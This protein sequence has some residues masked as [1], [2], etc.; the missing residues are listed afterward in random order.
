MDQMI[1]VI[2]FAMNGIGLGHMMRSINIAKELKKIIKCEVLFVTNSPF[3]KFFKENNFRFL[4][5]GADPLDWSN[6]K[7]S[8]DDYLKV[9]QEFL[10][11]AI[12]DFAPDIIVYDFLIMPE[13]IQ[14]AKTKNIFSVYVLREVNSFDYLLPFKPY[15]SFFDL[16]L[17]TGIENKNFKENAVHAGFNKEK[18]F[19]VGNIFRTAEKQRIP[20]MRRKYHKRRG[21][22]LVTITMGG[23]GAGA[24]FLNEIKKFMF[25][26]AAMAKKINCPKKLRWLFI[27]GPLFPDTVHLPAP[28]EVV[29]Y[30]KELPELFHI[31]DLILATG[32]YNTINE[33]IG[34]KRPAL[35]YPLAH[36]EKFLE[37]QTTRVSAYVPK[38]FIKKLDINDHI[39]SLKILKNVLRPSVLKAMKLAYRH[40]RH[41]NGA[42]LAARLI[43]ENF[44]KYPIKRVYVGVLKDRIDTEG[45]HFIFEEIE[46]FRNYHPVYFCHGLIKVRR[47]ID[48]CHCQPYLR[49]PYRNLDLT[50]LSKSGLDRFQDLIRSNHIKILYAEFLTDAVSNLLLIRRSK[51]PTVINF[52][53]FEL[54][55]P[56]VIYFLKQIA[57]AA[58]KIIA[59]SRFQKKELMKRGIKESKIEVIYT[60]I[61]PLT[62]PFKFRK[63]DK[64]KLRLLSAG[65]FVEKKGFDITLRFY[66]KLVQLYPSSKLV[67]VGRGPLKQKIEDDIKHLGLGRHI[68]LK[69][70]MDHDNFIRELYEHD[71]FILP[72]QKTDSADQEGIPNVLK[73]AM[74]S[75]LPVIST[76]HAGIPELITDSKTGFLAPERDPLTLLKKVEF[77]TNN[78]KQTRQICLN[79]RSFVEKNFNVVRTAGQIEDLLRKIS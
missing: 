17:L 58:C 51:L 29:E 53:G 62:I 30:E 43:K 25:T 11:A 47:K 78:K 66:K 74:A 32:G 35:I 28:M 48:D 21:E 69:P 46:A 42:G 76:Y 18:I 22:F 23:G 39:G 7:I 77:I 73:E 70:F 27:K 49:I 24:P 26:V 41:K 37:S 16:V 3:L 34:A 1:K 8:Y 20:R 65:R 13:V 36:K 12:K 38:G 56:A 31:S 33:I 72:C 55:D 2:F 68:Q 45:N 10:L 5:G 40:H 75:G 50:I 4:K 63:T 57:A 60:G 6:H 61:N 14:Y 54:S 15:L 71:I 64:K 19:Y 79:A 52:R 44:L 59:R 67:L 9:N